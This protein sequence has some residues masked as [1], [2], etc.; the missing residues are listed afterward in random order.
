MPHIVVLDGFAANPGDASWQPLEEL[1]TLVVFDRTPPELTLERARGADV[2]VTNKTRIG[3]DLLDRLT[4]LTGICVLATGVNVV[5]VGAAL[6]RKVPVCNVPSYGAA[7]VAEHTLALWLELARRVGLHDAAVHDG[8][9]SRSPDF[10]F[11][12]SP[13]LEIEEKRLGIVG[14]GAVGQRVARAALALGARVAATASRHNPPEPGVEVVGLDALFETSDVVSLHCPLTDATEKLVRW[15]RLVTMRSSA[16]L[17]NTARGG[18]IAEPDLARALRSGT[19]AG[20]ALDVLAEEPPPPDNPLLTA[21]HC[22]ITP[23]LAW[24][25]LASRRRLIRATADNV[26]ALLSGSPQNLVRG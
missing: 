10:S 6:A 2:L 21:P 11:W 1:G 3:A 5:D 26:H 25:T 7:S 15:Q 8:R 24:T 20:A 9:W 14:Y 4:G 18:L 16:L 17:I 12:L 22:I 13:Q 23:H 19:I